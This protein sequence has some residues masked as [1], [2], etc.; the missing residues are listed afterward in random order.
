VKLLTTLNPQFIGRLR[1][2]SGEGILFDCPT[3]GPSHRLAAYFKNPVD[4]NPPA[5]W[6][7]SAWE[8]EGVDFATLTVE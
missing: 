2:E 4:G 7:D 3:C 8:R 1:Q 6:R 5:P